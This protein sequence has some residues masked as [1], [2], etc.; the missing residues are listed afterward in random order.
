MKLSLIVAAATASLLILT[1]AANAQNA[2]KR[3]FFHPLGFWSNEGFVA[4]P[5]IYPRRLRVPHYDSDPEM[6][7]PH[8]GGYVLH[9]RNW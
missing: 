8:N 2:D 6:S 9:E 3:S 4:Q 1:S 7:S 5:Q